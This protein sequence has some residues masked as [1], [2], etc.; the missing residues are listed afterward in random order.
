M[1]IKKTNRSPTS[2][3]LCTVLLQKMFSGDSSVPWEHPIH[4]SSHSTYKARDVTGAQ[5]RTICTQVSSTSGLTFIRKWQQSAVCWKNKE[6]VGSRMKQGIVLPAHQEHHWPRCYL[7][8][9]ETKLSGHPNEKLL[10]VV[11]ISFGRWLKIATKLFP[12]HVWYIDP[13]T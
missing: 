4:C 8:H 6:S 2:P 7:G 10:I 5:G 1:K 11:Y 9:S 13:R 12:Y 3:H